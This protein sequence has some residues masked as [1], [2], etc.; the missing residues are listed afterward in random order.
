[1]LRRGAPPLR[2]SADGPRQLADQIGDALRREKQQL[3][4][5]PASTANTTTSS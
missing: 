5:A 4:E 3:V 1:M 2:F